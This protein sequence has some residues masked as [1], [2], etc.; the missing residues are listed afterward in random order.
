MLDNVKIQLDELAESLYIQVQANMRAKDKVVSGVLSDSVS[1]DVLENEVT[2]DMILQ[3]IMVEYG[4]YQDEG[5]KG[6]NPSAIK[7]G[8]QK[9]PHSRFKFGSG[10]GKGSLFNSLDSWIIRRNIA[11]RDKKGRFIPR[12]SVKFRI[13]KSI[14]NQGIEP[15]G[16]FTDAWDKMLKSATPKIRT[17]LEKDAKK[18]FI[19]LIH[20]SKK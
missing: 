16:F 2:K 1:V 14:Y 10:K 15:S 7:N 3:Y 9:A 5:V 6:K 13:A 8:I 20:K 4:Y 17:A 18:L 19:E 11:P 12:A